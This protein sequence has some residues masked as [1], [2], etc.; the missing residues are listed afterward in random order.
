MGF[1]NAVPRANILES[2]ERLVRA[3]QERVQHGPKPRKTCWLRDVPIIFRLS[4]DAGIF[5][6]TGSRCKQLEGT[7]VGNHMSPNYVSPT[8]ADS[9]ESPPQHP[10]SDFAG[11]AF[12][13]YVDNR[14]PLWPEGILQHPMLKSVFSPEFYQGI[15][16]EKIEDTDGSDSPSMQT[17]K[18]RS[19]LCQR[20]PGKSDDI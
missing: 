19:L 7:R 15:Q 11:A 5:T 16:L 8:V 1:F 13:R 18:L 20:K 2:V 17:P 3:C 12:F 9:S 14:L 10:S 6:A 4:F